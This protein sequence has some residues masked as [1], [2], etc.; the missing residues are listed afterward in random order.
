MLLRRS[1]LLVP[2]LLSGL[3]AAAP[4]RGE[5]TAR[6]GAALPAAPAHAA[7]TVP[8]VTRAPPRGLFLL[9][10][11]VP[12]PLPLALVVEPSVSRPLAAPAPAAPAVP[13]APADPAVATPA[14]AAGV[15][16]PPT[17]QAPKPLRRG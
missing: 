14:S 17:L 6:P 5:A 2:V 15:H 11:L 1:T 10:L 3:V 13:A 9:S 4:P 8:T 7:P 16:A 12:G